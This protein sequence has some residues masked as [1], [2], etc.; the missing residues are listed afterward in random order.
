MQLLGVDMVSGKTLHAF[1]RRRGWQ[2]SSVKQMAAHLKEGEMD[3]NLVDT[4]R[5]QTDDHQTRQQ[6]ENRVR[7]VPETSI[8]QIQHWFLT[9]TSKGKTVCRETMR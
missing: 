9:E 4:L 6:I 7:E 1:H 2:Y 8:K 3:V 5:A